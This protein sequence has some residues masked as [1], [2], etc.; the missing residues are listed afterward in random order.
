MMY[1]GLKL[2]CSREGPQQIP[3]TDHSDVMG[4]GLEDATDNDLHVVKPEMVSFRIF[5]QHK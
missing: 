4:E 2:V 1:C 5:I 3:I